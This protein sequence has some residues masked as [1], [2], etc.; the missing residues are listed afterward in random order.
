M[1]K[2]QG[3]CFQKEVWDQIKLIPKGETRSY[4]D[5]ANAIGRVLFV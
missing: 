1:N 5:I 3:T 4:K 2:L